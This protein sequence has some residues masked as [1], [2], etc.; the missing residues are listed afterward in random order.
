[1]TGSYEV[2][3]PPI[4]AA[5]KGLGE[6]RD[7]IERVE[8]DD[9]PRVVFFDA[10]GTLFGV[11]GSVGK[12]YAKVALRHGVT[13]GAAELDLAFYAA[14]KE[15]GSPAFPKAIV[16][17][18]PQLEYEWWKAITRSSFG[19]IEFVDFDAFFADLFAYFASADPWFL[20][21]ETIETLGFLNQANIPIGIVSNFDSRLYSVLRSLSLDQYFQSVTISTEVGS[22][23]PDGKIFT[24][25]LAKQGCEADQ[26]WHVGDSRKEDYEAAIAMGL[27]GIWVDRLQ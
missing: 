23:K 5:M 8:D 20:Y 1:M 16:A 25:A 18:I 4:L 7:L 15:A 24:V 10:V 3:K 12:Q 19:K 2:P 27:R 22:A 26:A 9:R 13:A 21:P 11:E 6:L 14:F 17:Q